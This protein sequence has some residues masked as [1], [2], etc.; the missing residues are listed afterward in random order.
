MNISGSVG[1]ILAT[2]TRRRRPS[3]SGYG[4]HR[5]HKS[6]TLICCSLDLNPPIIPHAQGSTLVCL[7]I[8]NFIIWIYQLPQD[9]SASPQILN[10]TLFLTIFPN[11]YPQS[12]IQFCLPWA[13]LWFC[14]SVD[15]TENILFLQAANTPDRVQ[16]YSC[17]YDLSFCLQGTW[18]Q[19]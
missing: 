8:L 9:H 6:P 3:Y 10:A 2:T 16:S 14:P 7:L 12:A 19:K 5:S 1:K 17:T 15:A 13:P 11:G 4:S 18:R